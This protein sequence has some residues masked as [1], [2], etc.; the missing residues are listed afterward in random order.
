MGKK[1]HMVLVILGSLRKMV[2]SA[3]GRGLWGFLSSGL[4]TRGGAACSCCFPAGNVTQLG[5][6]MVQLRD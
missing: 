3:F 2:Q 1:K 4:N 6:F 5:L